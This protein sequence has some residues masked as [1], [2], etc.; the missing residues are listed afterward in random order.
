MD[1]LHLD[2]E[3][4]STL[5]PN[6]N[7]MS[8]YMRDETTGLICLGWQLNDGQPDIWL[9]GMAVPA[10]LREALN[11]PL[12]KICGHNVRFEWLLLNDLMPRYGW[13]RPRSENNRWAGVERLNCTAARAARLALPRKLEGAL[14]ALGAPI[15]KDMDGNRTMLQLSKP[16]PGPLK[17]GIIEWWNDDAKLAKTCDYCL[18]D[19]R[20]EHWLDNNLPELSEFELHVWRLDQIIAERGVRVDT[21]WTALALDVAAVAQARLDARMAELTGGRV[22]NTRKRAELINY[23]R[24]AGAE[25]DDTKKKTLTDELAEIGDSNPELAA[26]IETR[27]DSAKASTKKYAAIDRRVEPDGR[28]RDNVM[29]CGASTRRWSGTGVQLQNML[30]ATLGGDFEEI[31]DVLLWALLNNRW[32]GFEALFGPP[33]ASLGRGCRQTVIAEP[34]FELMWGDFSQVEA[35]GVAVASG[36]SDLVELFRADGP[37]YETMGALIFG[38]SVEEVIAKGP[39]CFERWCGKQTVLGCGYGLGP[40][41]FE[42]MCDLYGKGDLVDL[43][44][45]QRAVYTYR[46]QNHMVPKLWYATG[47]A[48]IAAVE[49]PGV[50]FEI[51]PGF[52]GGFRVENGWLLFYMPS[53]EPLYYADPK[54]EMAERVI[55]GRVKRQPQLTFMAVNAKTRQWWRERTWGGTLVENWVQSFCR[56]FVAESQI[57]LEDKGFRPLWSSHDEIICEPPA[58]V[59]SKDEMKSCL[60]FDRSW[61]PG[62]P[63]NASV[64][65][66]LRYGK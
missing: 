13:A 18:D 52:P 40:P 9:P 23:L 5:T 39:D 48:A 3:T 44:L 25:I 49:N 10:D 26:V 28:V 30:R 66:G 2:G 57:I 19:V 11:D 35:R 58:G 6:K 47:D 64:K 1:K 55:R 21:D 32:D 50:Y 22:P 54:L 61:L 4:R 14:K 16:K 20:G 36:Q 45:S 37:V 38:M 60:V 33:L 63:L 43:A 27:L 56:D 51:R 29:Y 12:T 53:G 7:G 62:F 17:H 15:Q 65:S 41:K 31:R 24:E 34:G 46:E 8:R 59:F 42:M